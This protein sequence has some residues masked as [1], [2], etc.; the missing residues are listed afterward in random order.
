MRLD[1]RSGLL[2]AVV[3]AI[4]V[5]C[6]LRV[7][8]YT[9]FGMVLLLVS[10]ATGLIALS[11]LGNRLVAVP[12]GVGRVGLAVAV[13]LATLAPRL[14]MLH[15]PDAPLHT[16][17]HFAVSGL[18]ILI[19]LRVPGPVFADAHPVAALVGLA[20]P[21]HAVYWLGLAYPEVGSP[22]FRLAPWCS[23]TLYAAVGF[24]VA[25]P[26][27]QLEGRAGLGR[28][29][30]LLVLGG[31]VR[32][33]AIVASPDPL[34]DV[35]AW[36]REAPAHLLRGTNPYG[37]EYQNVY[38]TKR[39]AEYDLYQPGPAVRRDIPLYPLLPVYLSVP[40]AAAGIDVRYT[41]VCFDLLAAGM[42]AAAGFAL[43]KQ[44]V[45]VILAGAYLGYPLA[46]RVIEQ[47][48]Y[49]PML[50]ALFGAGLVLLQRGYRVGGFVLGMGLVGKQFGVVIAPA[51][52]VGCLR[53]W[54]SVLVGTVAAAALILGVSLVWD[55]RAFL[56]IILL[57]H[58]RMAPRLD[59][60]TIGSL[61]YQEYG[62]VPAKTALWAAMLL[63]WAY[64]VW[65]T[66]RTP[67][68]GATGMGL[69]L[70]TFSLFNLQ[71][72]L[73][74]YYLAG[75]LLLLGLVGLSPPADDPGSG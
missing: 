35:W 67:V 72:N 14:F 53:S 41:D 19:L 60:L 21:C 7:G 33:A 5:A 68:A 64:V 42:I 44:A 70:I 11:P 73:N 52:F 9:L 58:L 6:G 3:L 34:I 63:V 8:A 17:A 45:G 26:A 48:W 13:L 18:L 20:L 29:L 27:E 36:R 23:L 57:Q 62:L 31:A 74:Y 66:P 12:A 40:F 2:G 50:A 37:A 65:R 16:A 54:R 24:A 38:S 4:A 59:S 47:S 39:A 46:A 1:V 56:D 10:L 32:V 28:L 61:L 69:A 22:I 30:A 71:G 51:A 15:P 55:A 75:Y 49:E 25:R 43:R